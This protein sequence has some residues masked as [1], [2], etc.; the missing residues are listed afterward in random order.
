M[1][2]RLLTYIFTAFS[3]IACHSNKQIF[4]VTKKGMSFSI[5]KSW[6]QKKADSIFSIYDMQQLNY[7]SLLRFQ[8][9]GR[10]EDDGWFIAKNNKK[11]IRLEKPFES[12]QNPTWKNIQLNNIWS[13]NHQYSD[14]VFTDKVFG[15]NEWKI[16]SVFELEKVTRFYLFENLDAQNVFLSGT[17]NDWSTGS[18]PMQRDERGWYAD[19]PL[20]PGR[21]EYKFIIDGYW[22][23]DLN[24]ILK[25]SDSYG[26][27]NSVYFKTNHTF[28]YMNTNVQQVILAGSFN[29]WDEQ[30]DK[31]RKSSSGFIL[32]VFLPDGDYQYKYIVDG[33]WSEDISNK[34]KVPNEFGEYNSFLSVGEKTNMRFQLK[35]FETAKSVIL[36]G[37]FND[38]NEQKIR[39]QFSDDAWTSEVPLRKG[40]HKYKFIVD[41]KWTLDPH[42]KTIESGVFGELDNWLIIAPNYTFQ[43]N[44]F[45]DAKSIAVTGSFIGWSENGLIMDKNGARWELPVFLDHGKV[46]YK[47]IVD[48]KWITDPENELIEENEYGTGNSVLWIK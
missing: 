3:L 14:N 41:G 42:G 32:N 16:Q 8:S 43:L 36:T 21:H 17:F 13:V 23:R 12:H 11:T 37:S 31:L 25:V 7:D 48:G 20:Q 47:F 15:Y 40:L 33:R 18:H 44:G 22:K 29:N 35:G 34:E 45:E 46:T 2:L 1:S 10:L 24:N 26:D 27:F 9:L 38:W 30:S 28:H 19:V 5:D 6:N 39:M 4:K